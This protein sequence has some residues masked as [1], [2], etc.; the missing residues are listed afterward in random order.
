MVFCA[1]ITFQINLNHKSGNKRSNLCIITLKKPSILL[2]N[3]R[4]S[5]G[6]TPKAKA[7]IFEERDQIITK[8]SCNTLIELQVLNATTTEENIMKTF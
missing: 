4:S 5:G 7:S 1:K 6:T 3:R 2:G 8:F